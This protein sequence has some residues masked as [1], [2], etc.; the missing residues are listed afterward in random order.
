MLCPSRANDAFF[1]P[2]VLAHDPVHIDL[3]AAEHETGRVPGALRPLRL[4][5]HAVGAG[6]DGN[7]VVVAKRLRISEFRIDRRDQHPIVPTCECR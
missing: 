6:L 7:L 4:D 1:A 3:V 2:E 5:D